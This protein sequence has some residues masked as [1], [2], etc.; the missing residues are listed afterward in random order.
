MRF[1][2][3]FLL[4][5]FLLVVSVF[6]LGLFN[7][8]YLSENQNTKVEPNAKIE[9][10]TKVKPEIVF[11]DYDIFNYK[12]IYDELLPYFIRMVLTDNKESL[13]SQISILN[14]YLY[15]WNSVKSYERYYGLGTG[16]LWNTSSM[17]SFT[18]MDCSEIDVLAA[19]SFRINHRIAR[20]DVTGHTLY[21][22]EDESNK[23]MI[24]VDPLHNP[25]VVNNRGQLAT[26]EEISNNSLNDIK[27]LRMS[28][29]EFIKYRNFFLKEKYIPQ[30]KKDFENDKYLRKAT[31][32]ERKIYKELF[33]DEVKMIS[34]DYFLE[35]KINGVAANPDFVAIIYYLPHIYDIYV[36]ND[37]QTVIKK[38]RDLQD[39]FLNIIKLKYSGIY[40]SKEYYELWEARQYQILGRYDI[41]EEK[42]EK[43]KSYENINKKQLEEYIKIGKTLKD[44]FR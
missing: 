14:D 7:Y 40:W 17:M 18:K 4:V 41:A 24:M 6:L 26:F 37:K 28:E 15:T 20:L 1:K 5:V 43:L 39:I 27:S 29:K 33:K 34:M 25:K 22:V 44:F 42:F 30:S 23:R 12:N 2:V 16:I 36:S 38:L 19:T 8:F 31:F 11:P 10:S 3:I 35:G 32:G 9:A 13:E 21:E